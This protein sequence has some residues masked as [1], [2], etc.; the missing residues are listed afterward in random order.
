[1]KQSDKLGIRAGSSP[2]QTSAGTSRAGF[3]L[4]E[5]LVVI[6]IIAILAA[7]LFPVFGQARGKARAATCISNLKQIALAVKQY[8]VDYDDRAPQGNVTLAGLE[9]P[10]QVGW[11]QMIF[12]Y[13]KNNDILICPDD[14]SRNVTGSI[15]PNLAPNPG[16]YQRPVHTSY[17]YNFYL[18][19]TVK[20]PQPAEVCMFVDGGVLMATAAPFTN[21]QS[22][23]KPGAYLTG[24]DRWNGFAAIRDANNPDW[25]AGSSRHN[26]QAN[27][28]FLDGHVKSVPRNG[29]YPADNPAKYFPQ[30]FN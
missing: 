24:S 3:T 8:Q 25:A 1:M 21:D 16:S 14:V 22:P 13:T 18:G 15:S 23:I 26:V 30:P 4:I 7:I 19:Q 29:L 2:V 20:F 9:A 5:L 27:L 10:N 17:L 28:A 6:A 11:P 12:A